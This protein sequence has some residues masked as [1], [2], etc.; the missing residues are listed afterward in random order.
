VT[1]TTV[2]CAVAVLRLRVVLLEPHPNSV[3]KTRG[4]GRLHVRREPK[5]LSLADLTSR[6]DRIT[7]LLHDTTC[8]ACA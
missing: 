1:A 6:G 2:R 7:S 4:T 5:V 8:L 3:R